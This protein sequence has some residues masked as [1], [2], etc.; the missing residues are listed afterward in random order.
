M[1]IEEWEC[2]NCECVGTLLVNKVVE[3]YEYHQI[4]EKYLF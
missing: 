4:A 3:S 2:V 1:I